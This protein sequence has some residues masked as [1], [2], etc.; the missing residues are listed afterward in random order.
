MRKGVLQKYMAD[1]GI[2]ATGHDAPKRPPPTPNSMTVDNSVAA[3]PKQGIPKPSP[4]TAAANAALVQ[5]RIRRLGGS[6]CTLDVSS[7]KT[8]LQLK[9]R[10]AVGM[11]VPSL[12]QR[13][14][15]GTTELVDE[16]FV[17]DLDSVELLLVQKA[18]ERALTSAFRS[19]EKRPGGSCAGARS[20]ER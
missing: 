8:V 12:S 5:V 20:N 7:N 19:D 4:L 1:G 16:Q 18:N 17:F 13:L 11:G 6:C 9:E 2:S 10:V 3:V 14:L 15:L